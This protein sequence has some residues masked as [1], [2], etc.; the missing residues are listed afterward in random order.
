MST[1]IIL[2]IQDE[3]DELKEKNPL[4]T[5]GGG[6]PWI[7]GPKIPPHPSFD[8]ILDYSQLPG[9]DTWETKVPPGLLPVTSGIWEITKSAVLFADDGIGAGIGCEC[10]SIKTGKNLGAKEFLTLRKPIIDETSWKAILGFS[11]FFRTGLN[12]RGHY[13][14]HQV[15][16]GTLNR[17]VSWK[18]ISVI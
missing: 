2:R 9:A 17:I 7:P 11:V 16:G 4:N 5:P 1:T 18:C 3:I 10:I 14:K 12:G 6:M 13:L 8:L 15:S